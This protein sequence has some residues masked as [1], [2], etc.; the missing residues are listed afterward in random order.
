MC[1]L[2]SVIFLPCT[3][4]SSPLSPCLGRGHVCCSQHLGRRLSAARPREC[5]CMVGKGSSFWDVLWHAHLLVCVCKTR[6]VPIGDLLSG[7]RASFTA[8]R[9]SVSGVH[10]WVRFRPVQSPNGPVRVSQR[11]CQELYSSL[12]KSLE[13]AEVIFCPPQAFGEGCNFLQ[14][15]RCKYWCCATERSTDS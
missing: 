13:S 15:L 8:W 14:P 3:R 11:Q 7:A 10:I 1:I 2:S 6:S 9:V 12:V 5:R 4:H